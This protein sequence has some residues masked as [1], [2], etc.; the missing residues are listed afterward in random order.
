MKLPS[1]KVSLP[2]IFLCWCIAGVQTH[3]AVILAYPAMWAGVGALLYGLHLATR[4][5][6]KA[7][8]TGQAAAIPAG[9]S[10][11]HA[12]VPSDASSDQQIST[13]V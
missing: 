2:F 6:A 13:P 10:A 11:A 8:A 12:S 1:L 4:T 7:A 3:G 9:G 5:P